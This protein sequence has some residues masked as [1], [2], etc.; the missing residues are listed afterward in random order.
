M[1]ACPPAFPEMEIE[2]ISLR[3]WKQDLLV[4]P[5]NISSEKAGQFEALW[6]CLWGTAVTSLCS[7][8]EVGQ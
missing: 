2:C 7:D 4:N 5:K 3:D 8:Q 6:N 1:R